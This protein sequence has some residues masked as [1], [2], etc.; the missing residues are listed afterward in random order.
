[1][2]PDLL[3]QLRDIH[4]TPAVSWWP[5]APGWWVLALLFLATLVWLGRSLALR[6]QLRKR[7][8]Q[9]LAW[10]EH[11]N[12][13]IDPQIQPQAYLSTLNRVFKLVALRAFPGERCAVMAGVEWSEFLRDKIKANERA[14]ALSVMASGPYDPAAKFDPVVIC[15]LARHWI[16]QYG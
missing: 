4:A 10:V 16:R 14:S 9:M 8:Q 15:S 13:R 6:Y 5:P 11:L 2:N 12:T 7:R 3:S 1:M